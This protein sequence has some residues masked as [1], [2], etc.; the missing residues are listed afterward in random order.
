[1]K[2]LLLSLIGALALGAALPALAAPG[3]Q[4]IAQAG[5]A[6]P[7]TQPARR[8]ARP[9]TCPPKSLVLPLDRGPRAL[10]TPYENRLRKKRYEAQVKTCK[11]AVK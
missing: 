9:A 11:D 8:A 10:T 3:S 7:A 2:K 4:A 1:M 5:E 6:K